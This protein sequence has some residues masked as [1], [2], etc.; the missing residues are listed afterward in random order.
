MMKSKNRFWGFKNVGV[1]VGATSPHRIIENVVKDF[2]EISV[3]R[4]YNIKLWN[5]K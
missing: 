5:Y 2:R 4:Y 3:R 1:A